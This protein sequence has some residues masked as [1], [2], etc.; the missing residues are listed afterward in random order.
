MTECHIK[1]LGTSKA[2]A[3]EKL[4]LKKEFSTDNVIQHSKI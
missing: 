1:K 2:K 4:R 3:K